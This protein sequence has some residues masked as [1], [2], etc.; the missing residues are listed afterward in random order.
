MVVIDDDI[1]LQRN[2]VVGTLRDCRRRAR[3][4]GR[5]T[6]C[7]E[8]YTAFTTRIA[9]VE[10]QFAGCRGFHVANEQRINNAGCHQYADWRAARRHDR[11]RDGLKE[12]RITRHTEAAREQTTQ[13]TGDERHVAHRQSARSGF[14]ALCQQHATVIGDEHP[15]GIQLLAGLDRLIGDVVAS[16]FRHQRSEVRPLHEHACAACQ[17]S[18]AAGE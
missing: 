6:K 11:H 2:A 15:V 9:H 17:T 4:V 12:Q 16:T 8:C 5:S 10:E 3:D 1:R 7:G 13:R 14:I 18:T